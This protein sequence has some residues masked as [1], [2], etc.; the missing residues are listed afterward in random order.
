MHRLLT[1]GRQPFISAVLLAALPLQVVWSNH[2]AGSVACA[3]VSKKV[4][5][6]D[7]PAAKSCSEAD[8]AAAQGQFQTAESLYRQS[9]K[10]YPQSALAMAALSSFLLGQG[11]PYAALDQIDQMLVKVPPDTIPASAW[12]VSAKIYHRTKH[13]EKCLKCYDAYLKASPASDEK[14]QY[15]ALAEVIRGQVDNP[16]K[17]DAPAVTVSG[18]DNY[19]K[20]AVSDGFFRWPLKRQPLRILIRPGTMKSYKPEYEEAVRQAVDEWNKATG[21]IPSFTFVEGQDADI[22]VD[23]VDDLHAPA[24]QAEAGKTELT[25]TM[26]G[27]DKASILL[28]TLSPFPD[29]A[30]SRDF[31]RM[32][33]VHEYGHALG[34]VGHSPYD[35]DVMFP[36]LSAQRGI[37]T[38]DVATLKRL[39]D[40]DSQSTCT[41]GTAGG[42][43]VSTSLESTLAALPLKG[44]V[45]VLFAEGARAR[46]NK[47]SSKAIELFAQVLKL[48]PVNKNA[49][50]FLAN[51]LNDVG[52]SKREDEVQ[53]IKYFRWASYFDAGQEVYQKN[54][55]ASLFNMQL[56]PGSVAVRLK[57]AEQCIAAGDYRGGVVE[58]RAAL[59]IKSD[60]LPLA[61][62][63]AL[64]KKAMDQSF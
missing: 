19:F 46:A 42:A 59:K 53:A 39:Y 18:A 34:L 52:L 26:E 11:R 64:E 41:A 5:V 44:K 24:L 6:A 47:D 43:A 61:K 36:S 40:F 58:Y 13:L 25:S 10:T 57:Q 50:A 56:D 28:L 22:V 14:A 20:E 29:Q 55:F 23:F 60:A 27:V 48:D 32:I 37:T 51:E 30:M 35:E 21:G 2:Q 12:L 49:V 16:R 3:A 45:Q 8:Q 17:A 15:Q 54:I 7:D 4:V 1:R 33:A 63:S 31:M 62:M 9:V 38:R